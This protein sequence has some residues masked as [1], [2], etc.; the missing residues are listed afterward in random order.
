MPNAVCAREE[1]EKKK[2]Q[3]ALIVFPTPA[4]GGRPG[5]PPCGG[6]GGG[7]DLDIQTDT[8]FRDP[9]S[10][11]CFPHPTDRRDARHLSLSQQYLRMSFILFLFPPPPDGPGEGSDCHFFRKSEVSADSGP[12][13]GG[14]I[15]IIYILAL[16]AAWLWR[17]V[18]GAM[19]T[20]TI[21]DASLEFCYVK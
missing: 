9:D 6:A 2:V 12:D 3:I 8:P 16:S 19:R 10:S 5:T 21:I 20:L 15:F 14:N 7:V 4:K 17:G 1:R 11:D 13:P 18:V